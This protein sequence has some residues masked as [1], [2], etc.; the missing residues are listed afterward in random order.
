MIVVQAIT[1]EVA[2]DDFDEVSDILKEN[3]NITWKEPLVSMV[4]NVV[5]STKEITRL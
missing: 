1:W 4:D 5:A 2:S 3:V